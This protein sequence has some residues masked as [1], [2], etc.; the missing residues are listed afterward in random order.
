MNLLLILSMAGLALLAFIL[1][2]FFGVRQKA[3]RR[4]RLD[5]N[6]ELYEQ[7]KQELA[8]EHADGLLSDT[9]LQAAER[10][11]DK[12]FVSENAE[13]EQLEEHAIGR[14]IWLPAVVIVIFAVVGYTFF[15]SWGQQQQADEARQA[16]PELAQQ[17]LN[18][19]ES[20]P[21]EAEL[22]QFALGLRQRLQQDGGDGLTWMLY[23]RAATALQRYEQ[24]LEAYAHAYKLE[25][26]RAG[27]LLGYAQLLIN[28]GG[29]EQLQTAAQLL[30]ELLQ[31]EPQNIDALSLT[32]AV[33]YQRGDYQQAVQAWQVLTR[34]MPAEDPRY[35]AV[36]EAL[37]DAEQQ[38]AASGQQLT[39]TVEISTALREQIPEQA[40]LFV[41]VKAVDG[42]PMPAAVVRQPVGEFPV[43]VILSDAQAMLPDYKMSQ[44]NQW[45]VEARISTDDR[46]EVAPGDLGATAKV[47]DAAND[48]EVTLVIS[49]LLAND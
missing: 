18:N 37:R 20:A 23:A 15:G 46:I 11:L 48:A 8:Q 41:F 25:P 35:G 9:A 45:Q 47:I 7:R 10:E 33:A 22:Q 38:L 28:L 29:A 3:Q 42:A 49:E 16:L 32:G 44:L 34:V 43:E 26:K 19:Q 1:V 31:I 17:V 21:S 40:T 24:A 12:R 36:Q 6:R 14:G 2:L 39:V 13:L 4:T 5:V 30:A 27:V